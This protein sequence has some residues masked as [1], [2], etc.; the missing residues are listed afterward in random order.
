MRT[1]PRV[2][3]DLSAAFVTLN[4]GHIE[5]RFVVCSYFKIGVHF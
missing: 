1:R 3:A 2:V 4:E 5:F